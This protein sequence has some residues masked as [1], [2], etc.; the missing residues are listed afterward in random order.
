MNAGQ[1]L[2]LAFGAILAD[3]FVFSRLLGLRPLLSG[4]DSLSG[5]LKTG[6]AVTV[7]AAL[8]A[9]AAALAERLLLA[10]F[11]LEWLRAPV[12]LLIAAAILLLLSALRRKL[13]PPK[14]PAASAAPAELLANCVLLGAALFSA[15]RNYRPAEAFFF[16]L[17]AGLGFTLA[18]VLWYGFRKKLEPADIP[19]PF[20]GLPIALILAGLLA[21]PFLSLSGLMR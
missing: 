19:R 16:G 18:A 14:S 17:F 13:F 1:I 8:S 20:E 15:Q 11:S 12:F 3:N 4:A 5:A 21:L 10:P 9:P 6:A 7:L 2:F